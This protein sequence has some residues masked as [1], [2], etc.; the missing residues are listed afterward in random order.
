MDE[1]REGDWDVT[2]SR[3]WWW[4]WRRLLCWRQ[5]EPSEIA[6]INIHTA[7]SRLYTT[8]KGGKRGRWWQKKRQLHFDFMDDGS[9]AWESIF[10]SF[11]FHGRRTFSSSA[12]SFP[13]TFLPTT[14]TTKIY[15]GR[16]RDR[17]KLI[18][19]NTLVYGFHQQ[20]DK[21]HANKREKAWR[22]EIQTQKCDVA[23]FPK[24]ITNKRKHSNEL[25]NSKSVWM[26]NQ[27]SAGDDDWLYQL[28]NLIAC[29]VYIYRRKMFCCNQTGATPKVLSAGRGIK[30]SVGQRSNSGTEIES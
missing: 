30:N 15:A 2:N 4:W 19:I 8:Q 27:T 26:V 3:E 7:D 13:P 25:R 10:G 12:F 6:A 23:Y 22:C 9:A 29:C 28:H 5:I 24:V 18:I 21:A 1:W 11:S 16:E 20:R 14:T 17:A